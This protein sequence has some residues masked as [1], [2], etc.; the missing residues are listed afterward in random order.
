MVLIGLIIVTAVLTAIVVPRIRQKRKRPAHAASRRADRAPQLSTDGGSVNA[1]TAR[2]AEAADRLAL[3]R[4]D[5]DGAPPAATRP[6]AR[7]AATHPA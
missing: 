4:L 1:V 2:D 3:A 7:A 5:D 6:Q